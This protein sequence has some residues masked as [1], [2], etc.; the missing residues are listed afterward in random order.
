MRKKAILY[1]VLFFTVIIVGYW[2]LSYI[3]SQLNLVKINK[4]VSLEIEKNIYQKVSDD[5]YEELS[6][7][8]DIIVD[9]SKMIALC[10]D[11]SVW[12]WARNQSE[13]MAYR[14]LNLCDISKIMYAGLE[15][16][17]LSEDGNVFSWR[18]GEVAEIV[19]GLN[20]IIDMD[21]SVDSDSGRTR[22]FALDTSGKFYVQ[23]L[24]LYWDE[25]LDYQS[26]FPE[27]NIELVEGVDKLFA[28][29]GNYH[30]FLR[31][32]NMV[33]SIMDTSI[34]ENNHI[35]DFI[36]PQFPIKTENSQT[37]NTPVSI[38]DISYV[39]IRD[40]TKYGI[41][42]LYE[43]GKAENI[44]CI[45]ADKYTMFIA[46]DD[47][48]IFYW[49][50]KMI[51]YHDCKDALA[52]PSSGQEDYSGCWKLIDV[53]E[54]LGITTDD[55]YLPHV[56]DICAG[57]ENVLFLTDDGQVFISEYVTA[58]IKDVQYYNL[59]NTNPNRERV[60]TVEGLLLKKLLFNKIDVENIVSINTNGDTL[61]SMVNEKGE[62][63]YFDKE[64][65]ISDF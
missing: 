42:I 8:V 47:G 19:Q 37:E 6:K 64:N 51:K 50:S 3:T 56:I 9:E 34:W 17:A 5:I 26:G 2:R 15:I 65:G 18:D 16:Y 46:R 63:F 29:A 39:D 4:V 7:I 30:Y 45:G 60:K 32:D 13:E 62:Y 58:E 44:V 49:D 33:F 24:F 27:K 23:G 31:K 22:V 35:N 41:T 52:D 25:E 54:V 11:G 53:K 48:M 40:G 43:L 10:E 59:Q 38:Q 61:F 21:I 1:A 14:I 28:G 36:F 20:N 55:E 12:S 57:G